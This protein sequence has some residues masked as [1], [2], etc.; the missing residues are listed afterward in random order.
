[1]ERM[2]GFEQKYG[3]VPDQLAQIM[4]ALEGAHEGEG[5]I[6]EEAQSQY[7]ML[8]DGQVY[9]LTNGEL[10]DPEGFEDE[11]LT[12]EQIDQRIEERARA[13]AQEAVDPVLAEQ[14][15]QQLAALEDNYP[16]LRDP[17]KARAVVDYA[18]Q[19]AEQMGA[20][21]GWRNPEALEN[22]YLAMQARER[23]AQE[24][25]ATGEVDGLEQPG[26][27]GAQRQ[28]DDDVVNEIIG[29]SPNAGGAGSFFTQG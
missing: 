9:D 16:D 18:R 22:A 24:D 29:A 13:I 5:G 21:E 8:P 3:Q 14:R 28:S 6:A 4:Q 19:L 17:E 26:A 7:V 10:A 23:A 2:N 12:P 1:V 20:P 11:G 25:P 15:Q 27:S